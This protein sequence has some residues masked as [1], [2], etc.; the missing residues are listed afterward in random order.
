MEAIRQKIEKRAYELFL[1]RGGQHGYHIE[2]WLR[3]EKEVL[4]A[5]KNPSEKEKKVL[6]S[7]KW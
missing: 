7:K 4:A 1:R 6:R 3:A 5:S 2:D